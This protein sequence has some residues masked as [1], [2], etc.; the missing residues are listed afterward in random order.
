MK[1]TSDD[2][3]DMFFLRDENINTE[4]N[5]AIERDL[6]K[7]NKKSPSEPEI[8]KSRK[9]AEIIRFILNV[10][11]LITTTITMIYAIRIYYTQSDTQNIIFPES[12]I[13]N[14]NQSL[15]EFIVDTADDIDI[16]EILTNQAVVNLPPDVVVQPNDKEY[17]EIIN[18]NN[19]KTVQQSV[20]T[21]VAERE[22][23]T[24]KENAAQTT[25]VTTTEKSDGRININFASLETLMTLNGIGEKKAKAI[26]DYR[27]ENGA[28]LTVDELLEVEGIGEKTLE[29]L[30]PYIT[31]D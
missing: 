10:L 8:I 31:V 17:A 12:V 19:N 28:F 11:I 1:I 3:F 29:K 7:S 13:G 27:N 4:E 26:I 22:T 25:A 23:T 16:N 2:G 14:G 24:V 15:G 20:A 21:T 18:N 6:I 5:D 9:T 30:R